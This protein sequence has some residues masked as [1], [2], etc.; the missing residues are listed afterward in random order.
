MTREEVKPGDK[1]GKLTVLSNIQKPYTL[2][3]NSRTIIEYKSVCKCDCGNPEYEVPTYKLVSG[4]VTSCN[5]CYA[6]SLIGRRFGA[7]TVVDFYSDNNNKLKFKCK[8][9]CGNELIT[10]LN[11]LVSGRIVKCGRCKDEYVGKKFGRFTILSILD[12]KIGKEVGCMVRCDCGNEKEMPLTKV[13]NGVVMTCGA[14]YYGLPN[15]HDPVLH[16]RCIQLSKKYQNIVRRCEDPYYDDF[17]NYGGRGIEVTVTKREFVELFYRNE[18]SVNNN[19]QIDRINNDGNYDVGNMRLVNVIENQSNRLFNYNL[20]YEKIASRLLTSNSIRYV[21]NTYGIPV[22][23]TE[24]YIIDFNLET[25]EGGV[26]SLY[27]HYTLE[28]DLETYKNKIINNYKRFGRD[29]EADDN[30]KQPV[31]YRCLNDMNDFVDRNNI[32]IKTFNAF[33]DAYGVMK[34]QHPEYDKI[35][36]RV[37][38]DMFMSQ[39]FE[40][41]VDR[42]IESDALKD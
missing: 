23:P 6:Y 14:C 3:D 17:H 39:D 38:Y 21:K 26:L 34:L 33:M 41:I 27:V 40:D 35:D 5:R 30:I 19:M 7:L 18:F 12:K 15:S 29:I 42:A 4:D 24:F 16:D 1:F 20:T 9:E 37:I 36:I 32:V 2:K 11:A 13:I 8:C 25:V 10:D 31:V 22:N 28:H